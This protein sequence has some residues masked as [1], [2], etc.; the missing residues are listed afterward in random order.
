MAG[1]YE[2]SFLPL[3]ELDCPTDRTPTPEEIWISACRRQAR[4]E[5][6]YDATAPASCCRWWTLP[7]TRFNNGLETGWE[8]YQQM[9]ELL[10]PDGPN[11]PIAK[12]DDALCREAGALLNTM[13]YAI[14]A[15]VLAED[16]ALLAEYHQRLVWLGLCIPS[17]K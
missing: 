10:T 11:A 12:M 3:R 13:A 14:D 6:Q 15:A 5:Q 17:G 9:Q 1:G 8:L 16:A 2:P 7:R 4:L